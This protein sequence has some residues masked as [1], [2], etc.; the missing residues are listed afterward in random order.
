MRKKLGMSLLIAAAV[1][2]VAALGG[3]SSM[4][5]KRNYTAQAYSSLYV[6]DEISIDKSVLVECDSE[7][8]IMAMVTEASIVDR[9]KKRGVAAYALTSYSSYRDAVKKEGAFDYVLAV[10]YGDSRAYGDGAIASVDFDCAVERR[11]LFASDK[12]ARI[13]GSAISKENISLS[14]AESIEPA[15]R[16]AGEAI[17]DEYLSF[18]GKK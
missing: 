17:A 8:S 7:N 2:A 15:C 9:L 11:R 16:R 3:C 6:Q 14:F 4:A 1:A 18:M 10:S 13:I 12:I 5:S